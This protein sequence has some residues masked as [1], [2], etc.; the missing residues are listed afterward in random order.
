MLLTSSPLAVLPLVHPACVQASASTAQAPNDP[1]MQTRVNILGRISAGYPIPAWLWPRAQ[2]FSTTVLLAVAPAMFIPAAGCRSAEA[3]ATAGQP[4]AITT[5]QAPQEG[6]AEH[7]Q[8]TTPDGS[9]RLNVTTWTQTDGQRL[10]RRRITGGPQDGAEVRILTR[11]GQR[12]LPEIVQIYEGSQQATMLFDTP[13][14]QAHPAISPELPPPQST[15]VRIIRDG[16]ESLGKAEQTITPA[17]NPA[18]APPGATSILTEL[19]ISIGPSRTATR[20]TRTYDAE[21][22]LILE[23]RELTVRVL[24]IN[25]NRTQEQWQR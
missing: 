16:S 23:Q 8:F 24:G 4:P 5:L 18:D 3:H 12:G 11:P 10:V 19:L 17:P 25:I 1:G 20:T 6:V 22:M 7:A 9:A 2:R 15:A 14:M 21:G 13:L